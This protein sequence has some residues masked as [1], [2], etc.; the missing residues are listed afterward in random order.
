MSKSH[1]HILG[2]FPDPGY[3]SDRPPAGC[4]ILAEVGTEEQA[5]ELVRALRE[6]WEYTSIAFD[7]GESSTAD[8]VP[9]PPGVLIG[10]RAKTDDLARLH[11]RL[12][13]VLDAVDRFARE[14]GIELL[15]PTRHA[16]ISGDSLCPN[17][18]TN[19]G[20][21][22]GEPLKLKPSRTKARAVYEWALATIAGADEMTI[23]VLFDTIRS[24]LE[25][26]IGKANGAEEEKLTQFVE[27]LPPNAETFSKYLRDAGIKHH[28]RTG[29]HTRRTQFR[30]RSEQ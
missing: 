14:L 16:E 23:S 5:I 2:G 17:G 30:K 27:S 15:R 28:D 21:P 26:E 9:L 12:R 18:L 1:F 20:D 13:E 3:H 10:N 6:R 24:R 4:Y 7:C 25:V 8:G 19:D 22:S 11:P 29:R